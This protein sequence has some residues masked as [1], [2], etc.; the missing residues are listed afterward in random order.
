MLDLKRLL[1]LCINDKQRETIQ[2]L[3]SEGNQHKAAEK[4]GVDVSTIRRRV[5]S[6]KSLLPNMEKAIDK[7]AGVNFP[8]MDWE[9]LK[10]RSALKN[11]RSGEILL[12]WYK[13]KEDH[14]RTKEIMISVAKTLSEDI[15]RVH[16][17]E[18]PKQVLED[19]LSCY[20]LT[21]YHLGSMA[22]H[23]ESGED[24][25]LE[26]AEKQLMKWVMEAVGLVPA[27]KYAVFAQIGDF[28][29][30]D[31]LVAATPTSGHPLDTSVRFANLVS[32]ATRVIRYV[33]DIL[34][35][36]HEKVYVLLMEGNHDIASSVW[37]RELFYNLYMNEPRVMVELSPRPYYCIEHGQTSLF[38]HH[39][40]LKK[41][42]E[43]SM[44][45]AAMFRQVFGRTRY[46]YA[47][48][49]HLHHLLAKEDDLMVVEQ[50]QTLSPKDSYSARRNLNSDRSSQIITYHRDKG[51]ISRSRITVARKI[52]TEDDNITT[53][54]KTS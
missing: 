34:L 51:E 20:I 37:L 39:G 24:W 30:F 23:K 47:H 28:L 5:G 17:L 29:H 35:T 38:F 15:N 33:I 52:H 12:Q 9:K 11:E 26:I 46:S 48:T 40:H 41:T 21:D 50:H 8:L 45:M 32:A 16:V 42:N 19:L 31:G 13:T 2:A 54:F 18:A 3:I 22:W 7:E 4:L 6:I 36:K 53:N 49:G 25:N 44:S 43:L 1:E 27:S 14:E 10:G